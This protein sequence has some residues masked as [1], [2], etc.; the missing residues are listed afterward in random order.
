MRPRT[1]L[2]VVAASE[3]VGFAYLE[4]NDLRDWGVSL[5]AAGGVDPAFAQMRFWLDR[6]RPDMVLVEYLG[7]AS[8]KGKHSRA[9]TEAIVA[10]TRDHDI[11]LERVVP[12]KPERSKYEDAR[13]LAEIFPQL[14]SRLPRPRRKWEH[15]PHAIIYFEAVGLAIKW[16]QQSEED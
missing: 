9:L 5:K 3:K 13:R 11:A 8:L 14:K 2:A 16:L 6:Y 4:G 1:I 10:A 12:H 7:E 15:E